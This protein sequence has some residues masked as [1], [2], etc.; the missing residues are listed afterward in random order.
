MPTTG[1]GARARLRVLID[2][3][4]WAEEVGRFGARSPAR[5][6]AER[7]RRGLERDGIALGSLMLC[8]PE[9]ADGT[10]LE[11]LM[12]TCVPIGDR[13]P[14]QRPYGFVFSPERDR[15]GTHLPLVAYGERHPELLATRSV[16]ERAHKRRHGRY[17]DQ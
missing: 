8:E 5:I 16:Y 1:P 10:R 14:S 15:H 3:S 11:G 7:E 9:E 17:P 2:P 4:V 6:A 13:P 12:K